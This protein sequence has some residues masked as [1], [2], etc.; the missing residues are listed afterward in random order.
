MK[1]TKHFLV[2]SRE[3]FLYG[4]AEFL[5]IF[6][7]LQTIGQVLLLKKKQ[8]KNKI[9]VKYSVN[10]KDWIILENSTIL[11]KSL[12]K[13]KSKDFCLRLGWTTCSTGKSNQQ[14]FDFSVI[15]FCVS[16]Q[17]PITVLT[18][19][20]QARQQIPYVIFIPAFQGLVPWE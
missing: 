14:D 8:T 10:G 2:T 12:S 4:Y 6:D 20:T 16:I 7:M 13:V 3:N 9:S 11:F 15:C 17:G 18:L 5:F 19:L 1:W